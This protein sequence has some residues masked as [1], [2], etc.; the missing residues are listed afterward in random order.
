[1]CPSVH[2]FEMSESSGGL[3]TTSVSVLLVVLLLP[4]PWLPLSVLLRL[5]PLLED[6]FEACSPV[7]IVSEIS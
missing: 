1:M 3:I 2:I 5:P 7:L 4:L 6:I